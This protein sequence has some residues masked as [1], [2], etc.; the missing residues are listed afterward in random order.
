[1]ASSRSTSINDVGLRELRLPLFILCFVIACLSLVADEGDAQVE[2][3][4]LTG[5]LLSPFG[6][7]IDKGH[8][9]LSPIFTAILNM[10]AM[11]SIG[12]GIRNTITTI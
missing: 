6:Y 5:P 4:W 12:K 7:V 11:T 9:N 3:P 8:F 1:M 2:Y 10:G